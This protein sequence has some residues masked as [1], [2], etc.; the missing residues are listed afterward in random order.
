MTARIFLQIVSTALAVAIGVGNTIAFAR[1]CGQCSQPLRSL[2]A[3]LPRL[4][5]LD[6]DHPFGLMIA[7]DHNGRRVLIAATENDYR[8]SESLRLGIP[9]DQVLIS[10]CRL[11]GD[12][13]CIGACP[14]NS[15]CQLF[16]VHGYFYC[17]C[18]CPAENGSYDSPEGIVGKKKYC[19]PMYGVNGDDCLQFKDC[20]YC[21]TKYNLPYDCGR[22]FSESHC[23]C[24]GTPACP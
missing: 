13:F 5:V 2:S 22:V 18:Y 15:Q 11:V 3:K 17:G 10:R 16:E 12:G 6:A 8:R 9:E 7:A 14:G 4:E 21:K 19:G 1:C 20:W 23:A 24:S